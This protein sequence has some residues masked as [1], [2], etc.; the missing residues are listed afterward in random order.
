MGGKSCPLNSFH[1]LD[2]D[3]NRPGQP[4]PAQALCNMAQAVPGGFSPGCN[5]A[6]RPGFRRPEDRPGP[7][8]TL[9]AEFCNPVRQRGRRCI[10][11]GRLALQAEYNVWVGFE[12]A[13]IFPIAHEAH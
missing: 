9:V 6:C 3:W 1:G 13:H 12:A 5:L 7:L 4:R 8:R 10:I 2:I 11:T